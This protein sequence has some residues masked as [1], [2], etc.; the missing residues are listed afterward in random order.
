MKN[1]FILLL[2]IS[3]MLLM[4][5]LFGQESPNCFLDDFEPKDAVIPPFETAEQPAEDATV[6]VM[7]SATDTLGKISK[8]I[9]GNALAVWTG[10]DIYNPTLVE[11]LEKLAPTLIRYPGGSWSDIFFWNGDPGD[12]PATIP[13]GGNNGAP[14]SLSPQFGKNS[15][16]TT[17]DNYYYMREDIETEGLITVNYSYA[18]Y[19]LSEDPVAAAAEYAADWVRYDDGRTKFWEIGNENAGSWEAGWQIDTTTNKDGQPEIITGELYGQHFRV[20]AEAMRAAAFDIGS[21]IY[22][23]AQI[24]HYDGRSSWN[25]A[26]REWNEGV[27]REVGDAADFYVIHN[28][29]GTSANVNSLFRA[30]ET[31]PQQNIDF[32][33]QD[34]VNKEAI[35]K[36]I[37]L[38]EW[39]MHWNAGDPA[40]TSIINGMQSVILFNELIKLN[41]GMSSRWLIANWEGDG[42]FYK[43]DD[44]SI[45]VWSPRPDFFYVYYLQRFTGDHVI[46]VSTD[47]DNVLAYASMFASGEMSIV[48]LNKS[49]TDQIIKL[50]PYGFGTGQKYYVYTLTGGDDNGE[51]SQYVYVNDAEPDDS[52]FGPIA[53][54][55]EIP[56]KAYPVA[57][58]LKLPLPGRSVQ[59]I[60]LES[61][62]N[63]VTGIDRN[64]VV[65]AEH[66]QLYQNY[67][68]PFNPATMISYTIPHEAMV[69]IDVFDL[70]GQ[71]VKILIRDEI[72]SAGNYTVLFNAADLPSGNYFYRLKA[73]EIVT[74]KKML[75]IK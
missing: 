44:T 7:I 49:Q 12:L 39:N 34:I 31:V 73:D 1:P 48:V 55:E 50:S 71:A 52:Y 18:R 54:L 40:K 62:E 8:Y 58:E 16:P 57:N 45:P 74:T 68:N 67:P 10:N 36:P 20:F 47:N 25:I 37:A 24:L 66:F 6:Q 35:S 3:I 14:I 2:S 17:V 21:T 32:I 64:R 38:T 22:I 59:F 69:S 28:Y 75:I 30:A 19:G 27:F 13:D 60:L 51:F 42:M 29:Y 11:H 43:G 72:K 5:G 56:A 53:D 9:F 4:N 65:K 23:G 41:Y 33:R 26:D 15:W 70:T 63:Y 61:G 46:A